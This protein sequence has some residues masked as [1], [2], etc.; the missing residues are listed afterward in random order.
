MP[1]G[2]PG[3]DPYVLTVRSSEDGREAT[4]VAS[5]FLELPAALR[6]NAIISGAVQSGAEIVLDL[7]DVSYL[8]VTT[9]N[10]LVGASRSARSAGSEVHVVV[11]RGRVAEILRS[12]DS[13]D[14]IDLR[15]RD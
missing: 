10:V 6:L 13:S 1:A 5:G 4:I 11:V 9:M 8:P 7:T 12:F 15:V 3:E 2:R 14:Q